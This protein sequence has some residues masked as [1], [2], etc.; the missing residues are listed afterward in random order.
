MTAPAGQRSRVKR[1]FWLR[2]SIFIVGAGCVP[3]LIWLQPFAERYQGKT[4]RQWLAQWRYEPELSPDVV[5]AFGTNAVPELARSLNF[6]KRA[7]DV[8]QLNPSL[9]DRVFGY[10]KWA[11][12]QQ[13]AADWLTLLDQRGFV[14]VPILNDLE[15]TNWVVHVLTFR[16][17]EE[18]DEMVQKDTTGMLVPEVER[19]KAYIRSSGQ[20]STNR[21]VSYGRKHRYRPPQGRQS[22]R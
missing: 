17:P 12:G 11:N 2:L 9:G 14:V 16:S 6:Y 3:V 8:H 5:D 13:V 20:L 19:A 21:L 1:R 15:M 22:A 18:L 10:F 7:Y 4:V